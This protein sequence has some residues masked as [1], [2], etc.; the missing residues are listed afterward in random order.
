[1]YCSVV[2]CNLFT[3]VIFLIQKTNVNVS[4]ILNFH[5]AIFL[6]SILFKIFNKNIYSIIWYDLTRRNVESFSIRKRPFFEF[7]AADFN[8]IWNPVHKGAYYAE[9]IRF[10]LFA[11]PFVPG[12]CFPGFMGRREQQKY[13]RIGKNKT[14][15]SS[16]FF[17]VSDSF[18]S[19][20]CPFLQHEK[21]RESW[22]IAEFREDLSL[23]TRSENFP[24]HICK[25]QLFRKSV[26]LIITFINVWAFWWYATLY[27]VWNAQHGVLSLFVVRVIE[28]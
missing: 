4:R 21:L 18:R 14:L 19:F 7:P 28:N 10:Q 1:M 25:I 9:L 13:N 20:F 26:N 3:Y 12:H 23:R 5:N 6:V 22:K 27:N 8:A 2:T 11:F 15:L 16:G 24:I 17:S